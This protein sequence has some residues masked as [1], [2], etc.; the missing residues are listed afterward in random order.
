VNDYI[1]SAIQKSIQQKLTS[2]AQSLDRIAVAQERIAEIAERQAGDIEDIADIA[3]HRFLESPLYRKH[4]RGE[5]RFVNMT[6]SP[7]DGSP[8]ASDQE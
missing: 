1:E 5:G 7:E 8:F 4:T 3:D 6:S 2:I